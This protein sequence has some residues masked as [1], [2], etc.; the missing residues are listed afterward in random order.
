MT[1]YAITADDLGKFGRGRRVECSVCNTSWYQTRDRIQSLRP[2]YEMVKLPKHDKERIALNIAENKPASFLGDVKLYVGNL[3]YDCT[4]STLRKLFEECGRVGEATVVTDEDGRPRG[5][6]FVTMRTKED[7][8]NAIRELNGE[9]LLGR[10]LA[11]R[12]STAGGAGGGRGPPR[13]GGG[14]GGPRYY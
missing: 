4:S 7:G 14:G 9:E 3:N 6:G 12:I 11:V 13:G 5:F 1:S 10:P 8:D 2:G